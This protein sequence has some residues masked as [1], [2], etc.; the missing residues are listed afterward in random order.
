MEKVRKQRRGYSGSMKKETGKKKRQRRKTNNKED[1][2][3]KTRNGT[4]LE[5]C[6][7]PASGKGKGEHNITLAYFYYGRVA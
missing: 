5:T 1:K 7:L 6:G 3:N 4:S 2:L